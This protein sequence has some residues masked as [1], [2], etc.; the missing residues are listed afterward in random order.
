MVA[1]RRESGVAMANITYDGQSFLL[2]GRRIWLASGTVC[3]A[4]VPREL[5]RSRVR[6]AKQCGLNCIE[7]PVLWNAH[8]YQPNRFDF[9]GERDLRRFVQIVG[10]EGL[11]C[12]LRP[13][14]YVGEDF[15]LGGLPPWLLRDQAMPLRQAHPKFLEACARYIGAVLG[16][17]RDLQVTQMTLTWPEGGSA[18]NLPGQAAGGFAA[19]PLAGQSR[20]I[21]LMQAEHAWLSANAQQGEVYLRQIARYLRENGAEVPITNANQLFQPIEGTLSTWMAREH[22]GTDLRQ[23]AV[24]QPQSPRLTHHQ[25]GEADVWAGEHANTDAGL[26]AYRLGQILAAGGQFNLLPFH[27]GTNFGFAAGRS[28]Q[29]AG[30]VTTSQDHDA[31]LSEA[32]GRGDKFNATKRLATFASHFNHVLANLQADR[33]HAAAAATEHPHPLSII[34]RQGDQGDLITLLK[35]PQDKTNEVQ[36]MLPDGQT[37]SVPMGSDRVAWLLLNANLGGVRLN[38]TNLRPW[39]FVNKQMLVLFGPAGSEG[40]LTLNDVQIQMPVPTG[41]EPVVETHEELVV[42]VLNGEQVDATYLTG[43]GLTVGCSGL[44]EEGTPRPLSGWGQMHHVALDGSTSKQSVTVPRKPTAPKL[45]NW[46]YA[47]TTDCIDGSSSAYQK[48]DGP[49]SLEA[50][51]CDFGYGWYKF[52]LG[53]SKQGKVLCPAGGDRLHL[54]QAGKYKTTLGEGPGAQNDPTSLTLGGDIVVLADNLGRPSSGYHLGKAQGLPDHLYT[55]EAVKLNHPKRV[56]ERAADPF[57]L[58][59]YVPGHHKGPQPPS[60]ALT[61]TV[62]PANR[63]P[64]VLEIDALP[65]DGVVLVNDTPMAFYSAEEP[66][67]FRCVLDPKE[68]EVV[69]GGQNE[70][71]LSPMTPFDKNL[72]VSKHINVYQ[73]KDTLTAKANWHFAAWQMPDEGAF[74]DAPKTLPDQPG[75]FR[76]TFNVKQTHM[77]LFFEPRGLTK[78]Q[79][80]LNGHNLG[81][82]FHATK[83]GKTLG[84]QKQYYLPE[85]WINTSQPNTLTLFDEHGKSPTQ[86]RLA[87]NPN[88]PFGK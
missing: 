71:K 80:Y 79:L 69:T 63:K 23:L 57:A 83:D 47:S 72:N 87:Y 59:G 9:E 50:M 41:K 66:G 20:P 73:I 35:G 37:V 22:Q 5:W 70:L 17:V 67:P 38:D 10:E 81:R 3:Y 8:E 31:P 16:Q 36:L 24:V 12:I 52:S 26:H 54:Y 77:P 74:T 15:D 76:A 60:E 29:P 64:L 1:I 19:G 11:F 55:V 34:H 49:K 42:V 18:M 43:Q 84:P 65:Q 32:G 68:S 51:G 39:A 62:K 53:K 86:S 44:D 48:I 25:V 4:R 85:P 27:G 7:T 2:D 82:Y 61:W 14:P 46:Q 40:L 45:S 88:G 58:S 30:F 33:P 78:G 6:A 56:S 21:L 13:G 28:Q 75:W